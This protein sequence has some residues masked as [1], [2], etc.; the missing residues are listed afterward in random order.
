[1]DGERDICPSLPQDGLCLRPEVFQ[2][3][4]SRTDTRA[5][6]AFAPAWVVASHRSPKE[7]EVQLQ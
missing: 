1:M 6:M 3:A 7:L 5:A 2:D 4:M